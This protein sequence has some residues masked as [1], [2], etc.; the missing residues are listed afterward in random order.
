MDLIT[1]SLA[2]LLLMG[3]SFVHAQSFER[4]P[5]LFPANSSDRDAR[6]VILRDSCGEVQFDEPSTL[7]QDNNGNW[8]L[9]LVQRPEEHFCF[10]IPPEFSTTIHAFP[11]PATLRGRLLVNVSPAGGRPVE[12]FTLGVYETP[13]PPS[14]AGTWH[15]PTNPGQGIKLT[16]AEDQR[17]DVH[18]ATY[19]PEGTPL[20][21]VG[22]GRRD[23]RDRNLYRRNVHL[24]AFRGGTFP[25]TGAATPVAEEWGS[26]SLEYEGCGRLQVRWLPR[27][28]SRYPPATRRF[29][30]FAG[31]ATEPCDLNRF[32]HS[33][34]RSVRIY[35]VRVPPLP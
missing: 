17:I 30:Q 33:Q 3:H 14:V 13:L 8:V 18:W 32:A 15:D 22:T 16:Y 31:Q 23:F 9:E 7:R 12:I 6:Y 11:L 19:E 24:F 1:R 10:P 4:V 29:D 5:E 26:L 34:G 25:G 21:L 28:E 20:W 2:C 35:S 27:N